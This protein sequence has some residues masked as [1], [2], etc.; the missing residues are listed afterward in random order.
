MN[1]LTLPS[2]WGATSASCSV[3][4]VP[5]FLALLTYQNPT[6]LC[7]NRASGADHNPVRVRAEWVSD[8][9]R[10]TDSKRLKRTKPAVSKR[11]KRNVGLFRAPSTNGSIGSGRLSGF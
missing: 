11:T 8:G 1:S 3:S 7:H 6:A 2:F 5:H 4:I 9:G 10:P